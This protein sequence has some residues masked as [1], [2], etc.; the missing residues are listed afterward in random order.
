MRLRMGHYL[1]LELLSAEIGAVALLDVPVLLLAEL[2]RRVVDQ[3]RLMVEEVNR[4]RIL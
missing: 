4:A 1:D 2:A 3:G